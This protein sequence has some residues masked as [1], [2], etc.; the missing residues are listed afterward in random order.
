MNNK[1]G[2]IIPNGV[3]L[4]THENATVVFFTQ[5]GKDVELIPRSNQ[6]GVHTPDFIMDGLKWKMKSPTGKGVYLIQN[7][8]QKA[9]KQSENLILDLRRTKR[10]QTKCIREIRREYQRNKSIRRVIVI[11]K[12]KKKLVFFDKS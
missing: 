12:T 1:V 4:K 11:T 10:H 6:Q 8:F 7:T 9:A 2:R 3:V 5:L